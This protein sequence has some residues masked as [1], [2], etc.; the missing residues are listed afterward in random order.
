[1]LGLNSRE[2]V[3]RFYLQFIA[4]IPDSKEIMFSKKTEKVTNYRLY[5]V[6][7]S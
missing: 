5:I 1:M 3:N 4:D 6:L 7:F 2:M